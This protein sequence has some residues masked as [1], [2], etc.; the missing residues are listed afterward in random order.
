MVDFGYAAKRAF[1]DWAGFDGD[2]VGAIVEFGEELE[3]YPVTNFPLTSA[4]STISPPIAG[5]SISSIRSL[6]WPNQDQ[7]LPNFDA[8]P[9]LLYIEFNSA[10]CIA[11]RK[12]SLAKRCHCLR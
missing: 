11:G 3:P 6:H 1:G 5:K 4:F 7:P 2:T 9:D 12:R 8:A 10:V